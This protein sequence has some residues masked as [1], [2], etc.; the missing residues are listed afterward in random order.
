MTPP[1]R[2]QDTSRVCA[3]SMG[4]SFPKQMQQIQWGINKVEK[5]GELK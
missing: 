1:P 3:P 5:V 2:P 4:H